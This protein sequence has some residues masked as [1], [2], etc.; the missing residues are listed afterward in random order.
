M[1]VEFSKD[2]FSSRYMK[3]MVW[4]YCIVVMISAAL[5][6]LQSNE[7]IKNEKTRITQ[8]FK[9]RSQALDN[10]V[11]SVGEHLNLFHKKAESFFMD[12]RRGQHDHQALSFLTDNNQGIY[13]LDHIPEPYMQYNVANL[14][15]KGYLGALSTPVRD[16]IEMAFSLNSLFQA[17]KE[18]IPNSSW[19]YYT[20]KNEFINI[21][22]WVPSTEFHYVDDL[23]SHEF[24]LW[25]LP[26]NNP[27]RAAFWTPAYIDEAGQG[28]M[29]T[30]AK[31]IYRDDEF[32]GTVAIDV[33]LDR[34][35]D[36]VRQF[37][38]SAG[39]MMIVNQQNQLIAHPYL[40][41]NN[42]SHIEIKTLD[43][44][45][46]KDLLS[47]SSSLFK[48]SP[49]K[50]HTENGYSYIWYGMESAP[51]RVLY[52]YDEDKF[53]LQFWSRLNTDFFLLIIA[54][55]AMIYM[56]NK[57]TFREFIHPA[58]KLVR[59]IAHES[60]S[61]KSES[62]HLV[63]PP[64]MPWFNK[65]SK[66]FAENH[67]M[68]EEIKEKNEILLEKNTALERYMPKTIVMINVQ[69]GCG[70]S[71]A[72]HL[73]SRSFSASNCETKSTV[74]LEYPY[75]RDA[76]SDLEV[77]DESNIYHHPDGY[78]V[79]GGYDFGVMPEDAHSSMLINKLLENY[80]NVVINVGIEEGVGADL[81]VILHYA[82]VIV[83]VQPTDPRYQPRFDHV[84]QQ[85]KQSVR[86]DKTLIYTLNNELK[87]DA[88]QKSARADF[89]IPYF[90]ESFTLSAQHYEIPANA[91]PVVEELI[92]RVER[93]HQI[94]VF[95]PTT[96]NIDEVM[97]TTEYVERTMAFF[98]EKFG[99]A[100]CSE[101]NGVWNSSKGDLVSE[102]VNIVV[103]YT[104]EDTLNMHVDDVIEYVKVIK[105]E[106]QQDAM[107]IEI[108]KKL[109]LI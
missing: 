22:P 102:A 17:A 77:N 25:G 31:P 68:I 4:T 39:E 82:K 40:G 10:L 107:A 100:T 97:D 30:S 3:I 6:F 64:W 69:P 71:T 47:Q 86:Q 91:K 43:E 79:W 62:K 96:M 105:D 2:Q 27:E 33:T 104:T 14:S 16:E 75:L 80:N 66:I 48:A 26:K 1:E 46:P 70:S 60:K 45:L 57:V 20:S 41:R 65:I 11:V 85:V 95:I 23:H 88:H 73:L 106:L 67:R 37:D 18:N 98:G 9:S 55:G 90:N 54:L 53:N 89:T 19:I 36:Y 12:V 13:T 83:L 24:Y 108:N 49:M 101:A 74:Y 35:I 50:I 32:L 42:N 7:K 58:E 15:G 76:F 78:D 81:D 84:E 63:P 28:L 51:W 61:S 72:G 99:G 103:S 52:V 8:E 59:H 44:L 92:D 5:L 94:S 34:L 38:G 21:Y 56:S 109:I 87:P 93:V 29:V